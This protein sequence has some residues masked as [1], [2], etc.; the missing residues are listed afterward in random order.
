MLQHMSRAE[1]ILDILESMAAMDDESKVAFV[2]LAS[3]LPSAE[4]PEPG[5]ESVLQKDDQLPEEKHRSQGRQE[6]G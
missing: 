2:S 3:A 1:L 4:R 5:P 6:T